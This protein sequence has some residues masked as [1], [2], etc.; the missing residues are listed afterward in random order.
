MPLIKPNDNESKQD[1]VNRCMSDPGML[2]EF[3]ETAKRVAVC[4]SIYDR[5]KVTKLSEELSSI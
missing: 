3:P 5:D 1:F 4:Y 2:E